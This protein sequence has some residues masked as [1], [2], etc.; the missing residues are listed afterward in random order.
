MV[1]ATASGTSQGPLAFEDQSVLTSIVVHEARVEER[2]RHHDDS[3]VKNYNYCDAVNLQ[4][5]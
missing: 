2:K 4:L 5:V 3:Q 1:D